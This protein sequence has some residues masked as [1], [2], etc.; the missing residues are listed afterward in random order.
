[1]ASAPPIDLEGFCL[2]V[3]Y[4]VFANYRTLPVR[5]AQRSYEQLPVRYRA[6][7]E[8]ISA[9]VLQQQQHRNQQQGS[10][11][12]V[13]ASDEA[14]N[15]AVST[16]V[17]SG[18]AANMGHPRGRRSEGSSAGL[19][20]AAPGTVG[21][22][23]EGCRDSVTFIGTGYYGAGA[24]GGT[25]PATMNLSGS[26]SAA[27]TAT[28]PAA[29]PGWLSRGGSM[30]LDTSVF[31]S[32]PSCAMEERATATIA[33]P[34]S[35][36]TTSTP[37]GATAPG[38]AVSP[39]P[40]SSPTSAVTTT[41]ATI[42][43]AAAGAGLASRVALLHHVQQ[44]IQSFIARGEREVAL[45]FIMATAP[46]RFCGTT[47]SDR[48]LAFFNQIRF[49]LPS[50][51]F[52][53]VML[54]MEAWRSLYRP[55][56]GAGAADCTH[57]TLELLALI[58][59]YLCHGRTYAEYVSGLLML[60]AVLALAMENSTFCSRT[61]AAVLLQHRSLLQGRLP[62]FLL[63]VWLIL[64]ELYTI[65]DTVLPPRRVLRDLAANAMQDLFTVALE[66]HM[67]LPVQNVV[68]NA[69]NVF[70]AGP[71]P[72]PQLGLSPLVTA[73]SGGAAV[74]VEPAHRGGAEASNSS[75]INAKATAAAVKTAHSLYST[76]ASNAGKNVDSEAMMLPLPL[77]T[78]DVPAAA[79]AAVGV[80]VGVR[81]SGVP[82]SGAARSP[83]LSRPTPS[84][85]MAASDDTAN[86]A[87]APL[88]PLRVPEAG[89]ASAAASACLS[90][91][92]TESSQSTLRTRVVTLASP[93]PQAPAF[94]YRAVTKSMWAS[95]KRAA[96]RL[97]HSTSVP[98]P[99]PALATAAAVDS[100]RDATEAAGATQ[101]AAS[102]AFVGVLE[103]SASDLPRRV[104]SA[105]TMATNRHPSPP[106]LVEVLEDIFRESM[107]ADLSEHAE[108]VVRSTGSV[109][110]RVPLYTTSAAAGSHW[111]VQSSSSPS[112][113]V[114]RRVAVTNSTA[115][116]GRG[117]MRSPY[118]ALRQPSATGSPLLRPGSWAQRRQQRRSFSV[119][120]AAATTLGLESSSA[121]SDSLW[122]DTPFD[123]TAPNRD[124]L[125]TLPLARALRA[126]GRPQ[127][128]EATVAASTLTLGAFLCAWR[129]AGLSDET[130]PDYAGSRASRHPSG[131][132]TAAAASLGASPTEV[133]IVPSGEPPLPRY[134]GPASGGAG[135]GDADPFTE[136][137]VLP[138]LTSE[139]LVAAA[140]PGVPAGCR[141]SLGESVA[142]PYP[143]PATGGSTAMPSG[144]GA[145]SGAF[146]AS[147]GEP[148]KPVPMLPTP[149]SALASRTGASRCRGRLLASTATDAD[150][151]WQS[152]E[153]AATN[154]YVPPV[155]GVAPP[156]VRASGAA[157]RAAR[158]EVSAA[159]P[160]V[161]TDM[162]A[163]LA[164]SP[165]AGPRASPSLHV[166]QGAVATAAT[167]GNGLDNTSADHVTPAGLPGVA[168]AAA[169]ATPDAAL[170]HSLACTN[171][172]MQGAA[173]LVASA[174]VAGRQSGLP[175][176]IP[177]S[178]A[179][180]CRARVPPTAAADASVSDDSRS[181]VGAR[182]A[183]DTAR[184]TMTAP[185]PATATGTAD[186]RP[187]VAATVAQTP[188][189]SFFLPS[190]V[191]VRVMERCVRPCWDATDPAALSSTADGVRTA[192]RRTSAVAV[193]KEAEILLSSVVPLLSQY[194]VDALSASAVTA[195]TQVLVNR[196]IQ[197][198]KSL[199]QGLRDC[200]SRLDANSC[201]GAPTE[202]T[203]RASSGGTTLPSSSASPESNVAPRDSDMG[204][205]H[206]GAEPPASSPR[207]TAPT[208][209]ASPA[210]AATPSTPF[211][212]PFSTW[213]AEDSAL[214]DGT[215]LLNAIL[216]MTTVAE[217][218]PAVYERMIHQR[219]YPLL[220][221]ILLLHNAAVE[222]PQL[223]LSM[224]LS[225]AAVAA[226]L[227]VGDRAAAVP[228]LAPQQQQQ[229]NSQ[230][231]TTPTAMG[232]EAVI[233]RMR[234]ITARTMYQ[235]LAMPAL[236]LLSY[237]MPDDACARRCYPLVVRLAQLGLRRPFSMASVTT[238][239][240]IC[241]VYPPLSRVCQ[242]EL[243]RAMTVVL[244]TPDDGLS[245]GDDDGA[246]NAAAT[247][248]SREAEV[249][250]VR[251]TLHSRRVPPQARPEDEPRGTREEDVMTSK[252]AGPARGAVLSPR[253][254]P[255]AA[256]VAAAS[257][258]LL[259]RPSSRRAAPT[260]AVAATRSAAHPMWRNRLNPQLFV[261]FS[262]N[263]GHL[264]LPAELVRGARRRQAAQTRLIKHHC[265]RAMSLFYSS[266]EGTTL[267]FLEVCLPYLWHPDAQLRLECVQCCMRWLLSDCWHSTDQ[268]LLHHHATTPTASAGGV[269]AALS[270]ALTSFRGSVTAAVTRAPVRDPR[271]T[272]NSGSSPKGGVHGTTALRCLTTLSAPG[273]TQ[274]GQV[275]V[276]YHAPPRRAA[277][278]LRSGVSSGFDE[279]A[280]A[281]LAM[282]AAT[283]RASAM[284]IFTV[285]HHGR[286]HVNALREV[287][288][289]LVEL[290]VCDPEPLI[291][292]CALE[293]LSPET[294]PLLYPHDPFL[295]QLFTVL[296]DS[297][298]PNRSRAAVLLCALAPLNPSSIFPRLRQ[299]LVQYTEDLTNSIARLAAPS[300][301]ATST[302]APL[303]VAP[304]GHIHEDA[305]FVLFQI[306]SRLKQSTHLYL[307]QL[308]SI[309][310]SVLRS[311]SSPRGSVLQALH[312]LVALREDSTEEQ[313]PLFA[314]FF[315]LVAQQLIDG[316][317]DT[318]RLLA[319]V[320]ALQ[321]LLQQFTG[322]A[323]SSSH[324]LPMVVERL[325][326]LLYRKPSVVTEF[327]M[328]VLQ[329]LGTISSIEPWDPEAA[330]R[331][332]A[333][334]RRPQN[335][336]ALPPLSSSAGVLGRGRAVRSRWLDRDE[337]ADTAA[338][339]L[340]QLQKADRF[341]PFTAR[342][343]CDTVLRALLRTVSG[344][345]NGTMS[346]TQGG[347]CTC[348]AAIMNILTNTVAIHHLELYLPTVLT[349]VIDL[350]E[351][352][353]TRWRDIET[354]Y[355]SSAV[356]PAEV[357]KINDSS[358]AIRQLFLR[359]LFD[360][361]LVAGRRIGPMYPLLNVFLRRSWRTMS[362]R[363]LVQCCEVLDALCWAVPDLLRDDYDVWIPSLLEALIQYDALVVTHCRAHEGV[364]DSAPAAVNTSTGAAATGTA[365]G[366]AVTPAESEETPVAPASTSRNFS[367][368][369]NRMSP[370]RH[371]S[372]AADAN[373]SGRSPLKMPNTQPQSL[374]S[375]AVADGTE[376]APW[377]QQLKL[378]YQAL[379]LC[380]T[381]LQPLVPP[382]AKRFVAVSLSECLKSSHVPRREAV[383][384][385]AAPPAAAAPTDGRAEQG[386][387]FDA[388]HSATLATSTRSSLQSLWPATVATTA[389]AVF[390][391]M[392]DP[393]EELIS[394]LNACVCRPLLEYMVHSNLSTVSMKLVKNLLSR[395]ES[396]SAVHEE[397]LQRLWGAM[398][399]RTA[400]LLSQPEGN[401]GLSWIP[402]VASGTAACP[403]GSVGSLAAPARAQLEVKLRE[404]RELLHLQRARQHGE[405]VGSANV[406]GCGAG[407]FSSIA[408]FNSAP[409][410][411]SEALWFKNA[412]LSC[413]WVQSADRAVTV[414]RYFPFD[415][416]HTSWETEGEVQLLGCLLVSAAWHHPPS[417]TAFATTLHTYFAQR[418][419]PDSVA[420]AYVRCIC[421]S[422]YNLCMP[423]A[424][425]HDEEMAVKWA[426]QQQQR[427]A[428][429]GSG[430]DAG[431]E[432]DTLFTTA[433]RLAG[434][435]DPGFYYAAGQIMR[436]GSADV[437]LR[438]LSSPL[439]QTAVATAPARRNTVVSPRDGAAL[440]GSSGM[441]SRAVSWEE[442]AP[443]PAIAE[444]EGTSAPS[445]AAATAFV[446]ASGTRATTRWAQGSSAAASL[447]SALTT[448]AIVCGDSANMAL[449]RPMTAY[450]SMEC[451]D[452]SSD[453][454]H[455]A[456]MNTTVRFSDHD[457]DQDGN[458][459]TWADS[460]YAHHA[461]SGNGGS[462]MP[463]RPHISSQQLNA[464][465]LHQLQYPLPA[466]TATSTPFCGPNS[467]PRTI[468]AHSI[469]GAD[470]SLLTTH[471][472]SPTTVTLAIPVEAGVGGSLDNYVNASAPVG[473]PGPRSGS[474][475][476]SSF[477]PGSFFTSAVVAEGRV[478]CDGGACRGVV[479]SSPHRHHLHAS[480]G[481][482]GGGS[483]ADVESVYG[484]GGSE[485]VPP[486][487]APVGGGTGAH[488]T[489]PI[490]R[491]F[492]LPHPQPFPA[493]QSYG[494][495]PISS[496]A[497]PNV[498]LGQQPAV[499][500]SGSA[501]MLSVGSLTAASVD[502]PRGALGL[503]AS[504]FSPV[505]GAGGGTPGAAGG[506]GGIPPRWRFAS[507]AASVTAVDAASPNS[508]TT[509]PAG[510]GV[511]GAT[512]PFTVASHDAAAVQQHACRR[513]SP[514]I[515]HTPLH[516]HLSCGTVTP[517]TATTRSRGGSGNDLSGY[518]LPP[519][520]V[521]HAQKPPPP[522]P[523]SA[524]ASAT[525]AATWTAA[526]G[527]VR[528]TAT[529]ATGTPPL[530]AEMRILTSAVQSPTATTQMDHDDSTSP[531]AE[532]AS[533]RVGKEAA[534]SPCVV[535]EMSEACAA[536]A[537]A[538]EAGE[539]AHN[540]S[541]IAYFELHR[542]ISGHGWR[543]WWEQFC[544][545]LL[546]CSPDYCIQ[547]CEPFARQHHIA[548]SYSELLPLALLS[549]LP[550]C[551]VAELVAWL[552][553]L[554]D[555]YAFHTDPSA[556]V[557][558]QVASGVA[559][560]AHD[561]RLYHRTFFP[562][563]VVSRVVDVWLPESVVAELSNRSLNPP[564][565][566]LYLEQDLARFFSWGCTALLMVSADDVASALERTLFVQDPRFQQW[567]S[568]AAATASEMRSR[569]GAVTRSP[570]RWR[571]R[572]KAVV[573]SAAA[574][575][576]SSSSTIDILTP[577]ALEM[578]GF[579]HAAAL[580]YVRMYEEQQL[581]E[582]GDSR[583]GVAAGEDEAAQRSPG[584]TSKDT[585]T[586]HHSSAAAARLI[587]G[588]MRC[589]ICLCDFEAV[590]RLWEAVKG[591]GAAD[592]TTSMTT[593]SPSQDACS[594]ASD[595]DSGSPVVWD[596]CGRDSSCVLSPET[597]RYVVM[598][599]QALSRWDYVQEA[600]HYAFGRGSAAGLSWTTGAPHAAQGNTPKPGGPAANSAVTPQ[601][602]RLQQ[603]PGSPRWAEDVG[604]E[605][606]AQQFLDEVFSS[607]LPSSP[608]G[609]VEHRAAD[610]TRESLL[611][612]QMEVFVGAALVAAHD[613]DGA[614]RA[615][616]AVRDGL[617]D[618]YAVFHSDN[619]RVKLEWSSIFQQL[620]D[621][622]EG[623]H[624]LEQVPAAQEGVAAVST[625]TESGGTSAAWSG[626]RLPALDRE[627]NGKLFPEV[628]V[629]RLRN[630]TCRPVSATT[631]ILQLF[632]IIAVRSAI[633]PV[634]WQLDNVLALG[635]KLEKAGQPMR[636]V[637]VLHHYAN[638]PVVATSFTTTAMEF[639]HQLN[640][641][642][643]RRL[644][645]NLS[646]EED[647]REVHAYVQTV[648]RNDLWLA[649]R[650]AT[651]RMNAVSPT[652][653][654]SASPSA[655]AASS[656]WPLRNQL[657][658]VDAAA[659]CGSMLTAQEL[660]PSLS[661]YQVDLL[662]LSVACRR[663]LTH[664]LLH[665]APLAHRP[666]SVA[667]TS[668][669]LD[670]SAPLADATVSSSAPSWT[671]DTVRH[672]T[673]MLSLPIN[674]DRKPCRVATDV[675][676]DEKA[677]GTD[678]HS[679]A[680]S[681]ITRQP[682]DFP[683]TT[684]APLSAR[685]GAGSAAAVNCTGDGASCL[686]DSAESGR[687]GR[688][689]TSPA[690]EQRAKMDE[691][692]ATAMGES[693]E[694]KEE[695]ILSLESVTGKTAMFAEY[696]LLEQ[697]VAVTCYVP[698]VWREFG[699]VL[700]DVCMAIHA[701][702]RSTGDEATKRNFLAQSAKAI[703]GLQ[704]AAQLWRSQSESVFSRGIGPFPATM[705]R[706]H[707]H[708]RT[709]LPSAHLLLKALHLAVTCEV[710]VQ[711]DA[712]AAAASA[713]E[714][715]T[716]ATAAA[717][718]ATPSLSLA[719]FSASSPGSRPSSLGAC[720]GTAK[721]ADGAEVASGTGDGGRP[722]S[723]FTTP[724]SLSASQRTEQ[725]R[726]GACEA[727]TTEGTETENSR[728]PTA[729]ENSAD[730]TAQPS[731]HWA[732][733][734]QPA[735]AA[736]VTEQQGGFACLDFS[737]ASYLQ[738][739]AVAPF[740]LAAA[741]RHHSLY[742][743]LRDMCV[744]SRDMLR[745]LV[746]PLIAAFEHG[747]GTMLAQQAGHP[748]YHRAA[749]TEEAPAAT[750][751]LHLTS[752]FV[753]SGRERQE[754]GR[755]R[756]QQ[757]QRRGPKASARVLE[758]EDGDEHV[759]GVSC[760]SSTEAPSL[761]EH[762]G[763]AEG[764]TSDAGLIAKRAAGTSVI[765]VTDR[766]QKGG[767][768]V[769]RAALA[770]PLLP[771][772]AGTSDGEAATLGGPTASYT[773]SA[774]HCLMSPLERPLEE[775]EREVCSSLLADIA[776]AGPGHRRL[777]YEAMQLRSFVQGLWAVP[778]AA[779]QRRNSLG[780]AMRQDG[781]DTS[782]ASLGVVEGAPPSAQRAREAASSGAASHGATRGKGAGSG[783]VAIDDAGGVQEEMELLLD[784]FC[785]LPAP[786]W[787]LPS[788][789][790][791]GLTAGDA[792][793]SS[794]HDNTGGGEGARAGKAHSG[795]V[796]PG[797]DA[798]TRGRPHGGQ[799][800][801]PTSPAS[802]APV[803]QTAGYRGA[804]VDDGGGGVAGLPRPSAVGL[805]ASAAA[806]HDQRA[807]H[808]PT[809]SAVSFTPV[810]VPTI[811]HVRRYAV[812]KPAP[813]H[814]CE[815][816]IFVML[817]DGLVCRFRHAAPAATTKSGEA[818][819]AWESP[820]G[821]AES[822]IVQ[823]GPPRRSGAAS[824]GAGAQD[825]PTASGHAGAGRYVLPC[826]LMEQ[827]ASLLLSHLPLTHLQRP[828]VLPLAVQDYMT[829][830]PE[831]R[832]S[833]LILDA[834]TA[835]SVRSDDP[836]GWRHHM[837]LLTGP[838]SGSSAAS[839]RTA[840]QLLAW[841]SDA[842]RTPPSLY[843]LMDDYTVHLRLREM[844]LA[845]QE[846]VEAYPALDLDA[847]Q[848]AA[849]TGRRPGVS[850]DNAYPFN[851]AYGY[852][853]SAP[854][855][856]EA[857]AA[858][859]SSHRYRDLV[860]RRR[861][862]E[863]RFDQL[864]AA[865]Y[866]DGCVG[867]LIAFLQGMLAARP[868][869][870]PSSSSPPAP[871]TQTGAAALA[872]PASTTATTTSP[873]SASSSAPAPQ[874]FRSPEETF[875]MQQR[876]YAYA[877]VLP[878]T[879][880][881]LR[882]VLAAVSAV[883]AG[884]EDNLTK[885]SSTPSSS[886]S[887]LSPAASPVLNTKKRH[888]GHRQTV[889][890][891]Q[892]T[893]L[894]ARELQACRLAL[895]RLE[896][897]RCRLALS[898]AF[899]ADSSNASHWLEA[900]RTYA[901]ELSE[902]SVMEYLLDV[903]TRECGTV[904]VNTYDGH[905][906]VH[907]LGR[908]CLQPPPRQSR[909][910]SAKETATYAADIAPLIVS[911]FPTHDATLFRLTPVLVAG[912]PLQSAHAAFQYHA[913]SIL[914]EIFQYV[915]DLTGI[916]TYG[917]D[918]VTA[919]AHA[920]AA[921][922]AAPSPSS[923]TS[924]TETPLSTCRSSDFSVTANG[925]LWAAGPSRRAA[926]RPE[927]SRA[928]ASG[929]VNA[930][931][932]S[933]GAPE[934]SAAAAPRR[935][936]TKAA[937]APTK[938]QRE[939]PPPLESLVSVPAAVASTA[940]SSAF[941]AFPARG[942]ALRHPHSPLDDAADA[943]TLPLPPRCFDS[944]SFRLKLSYDALLVLHEEAERSGRATMLRLLRSQREAT[945]AQWLHV[946]PTSPS[947]DGDDGN[948]VEA[949]LSAAS[950]GA[951][952]V[953]MGRALPS[954]LS[955]AADDD[956]NDDDGAP[957]S[958]SAFDLAAAMITAATDEKNLLGVDG[959]CPHT[960][961][962]WAPHW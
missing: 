67:T 85:G 410:S 560:V 16:S 143:S 821:A 330:P 465:Q 321:S 903:H 251:V 84:I 805:P 793:G 61:A 244:A 914:Y 677:T 639:K 883:A 29:S 385:T 306:T 310:S 138:F 863:E 130:D 298:M 448:T 127:T 642:M 273:P 657:G 382:L 732:S 437:I 352:R 696:Y 840:T 531:A 834:A 739:A 340:A 636:A 656:S 955:N 413:M 119:T 97:A 63:A 293:S 291:R 123:G 199:S 109:Q 5:C 756:Q 425:A 232:G 804:R 556:P 364:P 379:T 308:L 701:E 295:H 877:A 60:R 620:S 476:G 418:F 196:A 842:T 519:P 596:G 165:L 846:A 704:L 887:P 21:Y 47:D 399:R 768:R 422:Y 357:G 533:G 53:I 152:V 471:N 836:Q 449:A 191:A 935:A 635:E 632:M 387:G 581:S 302:S 599:A 83:F 668:A 30:C 795:G 400:S 78:L 68:A 52:G 621:L 37:G 666:S 640:L 813:H 714:A 463:H 648:L 222:E 190:W 958:T 180:L 403:D 744:Q 301:P 135:A 624:T 397:A 962:R 752:A 493:G 552:R 408:T 876:L 466:R 527:A 689:G 888:Y 59:T 377:E 4:N 34:V 625:S 847:M 790:G 491:P 697:A 32:L 551:T 211:A 562:P 942:A 50:P 87:A 202:T 508:F 492:Q 617:R 528:S 921:P 43:D 749:A 343:W 250:G 630:I 142:L 225:S 890:A 126:A 815:E 540:N 12:A 616:T 86:T 725:P 11:D 512:L 582:R 945:E 672:P 573:R 182:G 535:R 101:D 665:R 848:I 719:P 368:S 246:N 761:L 526:A 717:V 850:A 124:A 711:D 742:A 98:S 278:V 829:M 181:Q 866:D 738:W 309:V 509:P 104:A 483:S 122:G 692:A 195:A 314:P 595:G 331:A 879:E 609:T 787:L 670:T 662:L 844:A 239:L 384:R 806:A 88:Q 19:S 355:Q 726:A 45:H 944:S 292:K 568:A 631:T 720:S 758:G 729:I 594:E 522:A 529:T 634:T 503:P 305:L 770:T 504:V 205:P 602:Q 173:G 33:S 593:S 867:P 287:V 234:L 116:G 651:W 14:A 299:V 950:H 82:G 925:D 332:P 949:K 105:R 870:P 736:A 713:T 297:H 285:Q 661:H 663:R 274:A 344:Y 490:C 688:S 507:I 572:C 928:C 497:S 605:G 878:R 505:G 417:T 588:A 822:A 543:S 954:P 164:V 454:R 70:F 488:L 75:S 733:Q 613:Y 600:A 757:Q 659:P 681:S 170:F 858:L 929:S 838:S 156:I 262:T 307:P 646:R 791:V 778:T 952:G 326:S 614:K 268:A 723:A 254:L 91:D 607:D 115:G 341:A 120:A 92:P 212:S 245:D 446:G 910:A 671:L 506:P 534:T 694:A 501:G 564:L 771:T 451:L 865:A 185:R 38:A 162:V 294:Y 773:A 114:V 547:A 167:A 221:H 177:T 918:C 615:L 322:S 909:G 708:A 741:T 830:L 943:S 389:S 906:A 81:G 690:R 260:T 892:A 204:A 941:G 780:A 460:H 629:R 371:G 937:V 188:S 69:V 13:S 809:T 226:H 26:I 511:G 208:D 653:S 468:T 897:A 146:G 772:R 541:L 762:P 913:S 405:G 880:A 395:L 455:S 252:P 359:R 907:A 216:F 362:P 825:A 280:T 644:I 363:G 626:A 121:F 687:V 855:T 802:I 637:Q 420:V 259:P 563:E 484:R 174:T 765:E 500:P 478:G 439:T 641:E 158:D 214:V 266:W 179:G 132:A 424:S 638:L 407:A 627:I 23:T 282:P 583:H 682:S 515:S 569:G 312:F 606:R 193:T 96:R 71:Q 472:H 99:S 118:H 80:G 235:R 811:M 959:L 113:Q 163:L 354:A 960:W 184:S 920:A 633:A 255:M 398:S 100:R 882:S 213:P 521:Q 319:T 155:A 149:I 799:S 443:A 728:D 31:P 753:A 411:A 816:V 172:S 820:H 553:A 898:D 419:G 380:L 40:S 884:G 168:A 28:T 685:S 947:Q 751:S 18:G 746:F 645:R 237:N 189:L 705:L 577:S 229:C 265:F 231:A 8:A 49:F 329:L 710:I 956:D 103:P 587:I 350:L 957:R 788:V 128:L 111:L 754:G 160:A 270:T 56:V 151:E 699:L 150:P 452:S 144:V 242:S 94:S 871:A 874:S 589:H 108:A 747:Y 228:P 712:R 598:S 10:A 881:H 366:A 856:A 442:D 796:G 938:K 763:M 479:N 73:F 785:P 66:L 557:P 580:E 678:S 936:G 215:E 296:W 110:Q 514:L 392:A 698:S 592:A 784:G 801:G 166:A 198:V 311:R 402:D 496:R 489:T 372:V 676:E 759:A 862:N 473:V 740:L 444:G 238:A 798:A 219:L 429:T 241:T 171:G 924:S 546:Q 223:W 748:R 433:T 782:L 495:Y 502:P 353:Q 317:G 716:A 900:R 474:G 485:A 102:D 851:W 486:A 428:N 248:A 591:R 915:R 300:L 137:C 755:R 218:Y 41:S 498:T 837:T 457:E 459:R 750:A 256:A 240:C 643:L 192:T 579:H 777:I 835:A 436:E 896:S 542:S 334:L 51:R 339:A 90:R 79:A 197:S 715:A 603:P 794:A 303:P 210:T 327:A 178:T 930:G 313:S 201:G 628:T 258:A 674:V 868:P 283:T 824:V 584:P 807:A 345:V 176:T 430:S 931:A 106:L 923:H 549:T 233:Q 555:F 691:A 243:V 559:R 885:E 550:S 393:H 737:A 3:R 467:L 220:H 107:E 948:A 269:D 441:G 523:F 77:R 414:R 139:S 902:W 388:A 148:E 376:E 169:V 157:S 730:T 610:H 893:P 367:A 44:T 673:N 852:P 253:P 373:D 217:R 912:L 482:G 64:M 406:S 961:R 200:S 818:L 187:N 288:H 652:S 39:L 558:Q 481:A 570:G 267:F 447:G 536:F 669:T 35:V 833:P 9:D 783:F 264:R 335:R 859:T 416:V 886:S 431:T 279:G 532:A 263:V 622:E 249:D 702:W 183:D 797:P 875:A 539:V 586:R 365:A 864:V 48:V 905:V 6:G 333:L 131:M 872:N 786:L 828:F 530:R 374:H 721:A 554:R 854:P 159:T 566:I 445:S 724:R 548:F 316:D 154:V 475:S 141:D 161:S 510:G 404:A 827:I 25:W 819:G 760:S 922:N 315:D 153:S 409:R 776:A 421:S 125:W 369:A 136:G 611:Q 873:F 953:E 112:S 325:H 391:L 520:P 347:L 565:R 516:H 684:A 356:G 932:A 927:G 95:V 453:G 206:N 904:L 257:Q 117:T 58:E 236:V 843:H 545:Y 20:A 378:V 727:G 140:G 933:E 46:Y 891:T 42:G 499:S 462:A 524:E 390:D 619:D 277:K 358:E 348:L 679:P 24:R 207:A 845:A 27:S 450:P 57:M 186:G 951:T 386:S 731:P 320:A 65:D 494:P 832:T 911:P 743:A 544:L 518:Q 812:L 487:H 853:V 745:Q 383:R 781:T 342:A 276:P 464:N 571:R 926:L 54:A 817:S 284:P 394:F 810:T 537:S 134:F 734:P 766:R 22:V 857:A 917:V 456:E 289:H 861:M 55:S 623:M 381:S 576:K 323:H 814:Q 849:E 839:L 654:F 567:L 590:L 722:C 901:K 934:P 946:T 841:S 290:A 1:M 434:M 792:G 272:A 469:N 17:G 324:T 415:A 477:Y 647:L 286:T 336:Y 230:S 940:P 271:T 735:A 561:I 578:L 695:A 789:F 774:P 318:A 826:A 351:K 247:T 412:A 470:T 895:F 525:S 769:P 517:A 275:R 869:P 683:A 604:E 860:Q 375:A 129:I 72:Q 76:A 831:H 145:S 718:V 764:D 800:A 686:H 337:R 435:R 480:L 585:A 427:V 440:P 803:T 650:A 203:A 147:T 224:P 575:A 346:Q 304:P 823:L 426:V 89:G 649:R 93:V 700:F 597:A 338:E 432:S 401:N 608:G 461:R 423:L 667:V 349:L 658:M 775:A 664:V 779:S 675:V 62:T 894:S 574:A 74:S 908:Y 808:S 227:K 660:G 703:H 133:S 370:A 939:P 767:R 889:A 458:R 706:R 175:A 361:V 36:L 538:H 680:G 612:R 513:L 438:H 15:V 2:A 601:V 899:S 209:T 396:L 261:P 360:L 916:A 707:G 618:S 709:A 328:A 194:Y 693:V 919:F 281:G 7:L 655:A